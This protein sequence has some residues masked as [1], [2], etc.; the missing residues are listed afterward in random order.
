[1][2]APTSDASNILEK[3]AQF[4]EKV[5]RFFKNRSV[6]E[7]DCPALCASPSIDAHIDVME[8]LLIDGQRAYLHPS[9]EYGM[10]RL[11]C[12]YGK[13]IY[14][15]SHVFRDNENGPLH[16]PEFTLVE[17][18]RCNM[19]FS[20]FIEE[21]L[22][23]IRLFLGK[24]KAIILTYREAL[25]RYARIDPF[26]A[27]P[28][29]LYSSMQEGL[30]PEAALWDKETL[31]QLLFSI[32]VEPHL[33]ELTVVI[34]YPKEQAALSRVSM[35]EGIEVAERFEVYYKGIELANGYHELADAKE[36]RARLC[37]ENEKRIALGKSSFPL[38]EGFLH[39]LEQGLPDCC[40]VAAG[41]DRLLMLHL[42]GARLEKGIGHAHGHGRG[43]EREE[44]F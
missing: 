26:H 6:L 35:K 15:M 32:H 31:L 17:W 20:F 29:E 11:L 7:V 27:S 4:F 2:T 30:S 1:V 39:A 43:H 18:Y 12:A 34:D 10:K 41:F 42:G 5:R 36:Q 9:P 25:M 40:G 14:Q 22:N 21:T 28:Q 16:K 19:P 44:L 13:D 38:D 37:K 23:F 3:R 33:K 8:V 24:Q